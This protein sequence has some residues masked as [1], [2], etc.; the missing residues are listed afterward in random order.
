MV[1][2][3]EPNQQV[4]ESLAVAIERARPG[5]P[6]TL[7]R[8]RAGALRAARS[9][10]WQTNLRLAILGPGT[11]DGPALREAL[12]AH[13]PFVAFSLNGLD[14]SPPGA[15]AVYRFE[16]QWTTLRQ[17]MDEVLGKWLG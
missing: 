12:G 11:A 10:A 13:V 9:D 3:V 2:L 8:D 4:G 5:T 15:D 14:P 17:T 1:L 7:V 6:V 16:L